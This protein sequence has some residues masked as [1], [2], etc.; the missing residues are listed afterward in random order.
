MYMDEVEH[1][2]RK[3]VGIDADSKIN[4]FKYAQYKK[5]FSTYSDSK[6]E[7]AVLVAEGTIMPGKAPA[8]QE[9][10]GSDSFIK[11][12]TKLRENDRVK[13]VV[14]RINSPGGS[15]IAADAM[16]REIS[17]TAK[18]KPV[19]ASMDVKIDGDNV[20]RLQPT[21][22]VLHRPAPDGAMLAS[23]CGADCVPLV[24]SADA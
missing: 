17:L 24:R 23:G 14:L 9:I 15:S 11:E 21:R 7:V 20:V 1:A 4:F 8:G 18:V 3:R 5:S 19:I 13:A 22:A 12:I 6:N 2:I 10:V 16:W